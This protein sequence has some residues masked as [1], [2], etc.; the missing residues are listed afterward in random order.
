MKLRLAYHKLWFMK[1][2]VYF[3]LGQDIRGN[4]VKGAV[5]YVKKDQYLRY[6][7]Y[8]HNKLHLLMYNQRDNYDAVFNPFLALE[9][10]DFN[11]KIMDTL[12]TNSFYNFL[13]DM[14]EKYITLGKINEIEGFKGKGMIYHRFNAP[15][16][17]IKAQEV[18][19]A[20]VENKYSIVEKGQLN[21]LD[22][23]VFFKKG[24]AIISPWHDIPLFEDEEKKIYNMV[25]EI[26]R[27]SNA[28][29]EMSTAD[30]ATPIKQDSKNGVPRFVNNIF[31]F[32][33]YPWNYGA[34][35]QTWEDPSHI[36]AKTE[37]KGD[38]D[39]IDV[40]EVGTT[41]HKVGDIIQV[42]VLGILAMIDEGETDWKILAI[43]VN[44]P[45]AHSLN[46]TA[47][48][49][50]AF[51]GLIG[52]SKTWFEIYKVPTGKALNKFAFNGDWQDVETTHAII[53]ETHESWK[54]LIKNEQPTLNTESFNG[55][56]AY[57]AEDA[58][59]NA[60]LS[61]QPSHSEPAPVP[62]TVSNTFYYDKMSMF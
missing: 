52:A 51:P 1:K 2:A 45:L 40:I 25:V 47:D 55:D 61:K 56:A 58:K 34:L 37:A 33:G 50:L 6:L 36:D 48:V 32:C 57:P 11:E 46:N 17:E 21:S 22:Y 20:M 59:F 49:A 12:Y 23:R 39:P 24:D 5:V 16:V 4:Q 7:Q 13:D 60:I 19:S 3:L 54:Q 42:K 9:G 18:G 8:V 14:W 10:L 38:N 43:D 30:P 28:K 41:T 44:D 35:P 62:D 53:A 31:P 29:M 26:P 27:F 15:V